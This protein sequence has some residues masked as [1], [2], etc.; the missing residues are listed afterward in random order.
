[1]TL[2]VE[3]RLAGDVAKL[4]DL[5]PVQLASPGLEVLDALDEPAGM[6]V[7]RL[8]PVLAVQVHR[9][10]HGSFSLDGL[11]WLGRPE[12]DII[13][14]GKAS[15]GCTFLQ[16]PS[17][18][19][20]AACVV[21]QHRNAGLREYNVPGPFLDGLPKLGVDDAEL[22]PV[23]AARQRRALELADHIG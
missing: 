20:V 21:G 1:V 16:T 23:Q 11:R 6:D 17:A 3:E 22:R 18:V 12:S 4:L 5:D 7:G 9:C 2:Q 8:V 13:G 14:H 10:A 15:Y 19:S